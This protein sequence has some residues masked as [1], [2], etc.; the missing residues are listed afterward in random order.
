MPIFSQLLDSTVNPRKVI[1]KRE[2]KFQDYTRYIN[3]VKA[4]RT[5]DRSLLLSARDFYALHTQL[6]EELPIFLEGYTKILDLALV[7]FADAQ[8]RYFKG[9]RNR[10]GEYSQRWISRTRSPDPDSLNTGRGIIKAWHDAW[11][12]Y[13]D[14]MERFQCTKPGEFG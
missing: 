3:A 1:L 8:S 10:L 5:P 7:A 11:Q 12:P 4:K 2:S 6:V 14:A 13:A 9:V